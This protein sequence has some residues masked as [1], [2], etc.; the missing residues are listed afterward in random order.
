[1]CERKALERQRLPP[2]LLRPVLRQ[3]Q[4]QDYQD[5]R[6][7]KLNGLGKQKQPVETG[8]AALFT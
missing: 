8:G 7:Q 6:M 3:K 4:Q 5:L 1:M 2:A